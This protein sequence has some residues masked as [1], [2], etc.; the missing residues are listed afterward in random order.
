MK[1]FAAILF[2]KMNFIW[3]AW[4]ASWPSASLRRDAIASLSCAG[5]LSGL[6][7]LSESLGGGLK[8][9]SLSFCCLQCLKS[10]TEIS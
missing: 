10:C 9:N 3:G 8:L 1:V 5:F 6:A 7:G 2:T 4:S